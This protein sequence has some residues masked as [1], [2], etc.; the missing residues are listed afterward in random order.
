MYTKALVRGWLKGYS[1]LK[2]ALSNFLRYQYPH[3]FDTPIVKD[4]YPG[5]EH[6]LALEGLQPHDPDEYLSQIVRFI[7]YKKSKGN[8]F[9]DIDG[10]AVLDLHCHYGSLPLGYNHDYMINQRD[11][12]LYDRFIGHNAKLGELPPHDYADILRK[13]VMPAAPEGMNQ[14]H[15]TD[16]AIT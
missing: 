10:N 6:R 8:F 9:T 3:D 2:Y 16:G 7:D 14:V 4:S 13:I 11:S 12:W 15:L 1:G 5:L